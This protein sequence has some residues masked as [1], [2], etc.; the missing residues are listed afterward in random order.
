MVIS[1][2]PSGLQ[3]SSQYRRLQRR[4]THRR[5]LP[6]ENQEPRNMLEDLSSRCS[7]SDRSE[8]CGYFINNHETTSKHLAKELIS[9]HL[10]L[11]HRFVNL[12]SKFIWTVRLSRINLK[13]ARKSNRFHKHSG[14]LKSKS[15]PVTLTLP[16]FVRFVKFV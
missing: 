6:R 5:T 2:I 12:E 7:V 13:V 11:I 10:I 15:L 9:N 1:D 4:R 16:Y 14:F 3:S 8:L